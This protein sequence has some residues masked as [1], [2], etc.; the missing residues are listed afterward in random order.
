[1]PAC[2][3][4][5]VEE[6]LP[7]QSSKAPVSYLVLEA[8]PTLG[9]FGRLGWIRHCVWRDP[10][11]GQQEEWPNC[12]WPLVLQLM[13]WCGTFCAKALQ[14]AL[15]QNSPPAHQLAR[16]WPQRDHIS[17]AANVTLYCVASVSA[18]PRE[19]VSGET[20]AAAQGSR[21]R[22]LCPV[23]VLCNSLL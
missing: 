20:S 12:S 7:G 23:Q 9:R 6:R 22:N 2:C 10:A 16:G 15:L 13:P 11:L 21:G 17:D 19:P 18:D 8:G 4:K 1:M 3:T 14:G 5:P